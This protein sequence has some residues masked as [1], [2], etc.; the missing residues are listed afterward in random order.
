V[1]HRVRHIDAV[2]RVDGQ[3]L[4]AA[5]LTGSRAEPADGEQLG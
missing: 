3:R 5:E 1:V 2:G 4:G